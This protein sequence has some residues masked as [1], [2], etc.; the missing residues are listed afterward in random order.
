MGES[1]FTRR[2]AGGGGSVIKYTNA[3]TNQ[4]PTFGSGGTEL[5]K[6]N[7]PTPLSISSYLQFAATSNETFALFGGGSSSAV[8]NAYNTSLTRSNPTDLSATRRLL[9]ATAIGGFALFGGGMDGTFNGLTTVDAYNTSLTRSIPTVLSARRGLLEAT[10]IAG[11]ALFG[12]GNNTTVD[13]YGLA[14]GFTYNLITP[15]LSNFTITYKYD[16]NTI[17]TGTVG[18]GQTLSSTTAFTGTLEFPENI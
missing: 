3:F 16:F 6:A 18:E 11:F 15:Q 13:A 7:N 5:A 12:G 17:G 8:V 14:T 1:T 9:A 4:I 2:G 10:S